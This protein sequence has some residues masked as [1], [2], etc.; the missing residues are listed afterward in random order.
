MLSR[1][2]MMQHLESKLE[3]HE[4]KNFN[5]DLASAHGASK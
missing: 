5:L 1:D 3:E 4:K 2:D